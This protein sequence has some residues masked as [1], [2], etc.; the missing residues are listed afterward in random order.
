[1]TISRHFNHSRHLAFLPLSSL[2]SL[3]SSLT[4]VANTQNTAEPDSALQRFEGFVHNTL[5]VVTVW[6]RNVQVTSFFLDQC[7]CTESLDQNG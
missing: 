7:S 2:E 6:S 4:S 1:M 5:P 3:P